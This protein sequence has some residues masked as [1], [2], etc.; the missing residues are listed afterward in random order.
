MNES[1]KLRAL[2]TRVPYVPRAPRA[3]LSVDSGGD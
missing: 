3:F 1:A 2:R